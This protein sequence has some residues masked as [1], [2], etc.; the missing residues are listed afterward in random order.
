MEKAS[1]SQLIKRRLLVEELTRARRSDDA[2]RFVEVFRRSTVDPN[3]HQIEAAMFALRRLSAGGAMLGDEVGLGKTIEAGLVITQLRAEGKAHVLVIVPLSLARQWQV[4]LQDLFS[5][6]STLVGQA[7]IGEQISRG[8]QIVGRE[9]ASTAKGRAYLQT[10]GPWDLVIIDEAHEMFSN[11]HVRFSKKDGEYLRSLSKG[12]A[13]RAA[14]VRELIEGS[15]ILLLTAT[16]LQNNL[17]EL[18]GLVQY[19][20]PDHQ[21]LGKFHEF[22]SLFVTGEG[23]RAVVP[24]LAE[25]LRRRLSLVLKRTL[26]H[27]A[28]PF[29]KQPF[30]KRHVHTANFSPESAEADVY[31]AVSRWLAQDT[32]AAYR[33]GHR[34]LMALQLRRR[35][36]SSLEAL[37]TTFKSIRDRMLKMQETGIYPSKSDAEF[38]LEDLSDESEPVPVDRELLDRDLQE[39]GKIEDL[40]RKALSQGVDAKKKKLLE[41][42]QQLESKSIE[43][44]VSD[45]VVIFT[46]SVK[47]LNTLQAFLEE[48]GFANQVTVFAGTND[49]EIAKRAYSSWYEEQGKFLSSPLDINA[50][51][52]GA[53]V[54][55][56]R[57]RTKIF[58]A[59]EAGAK[60][61][62]LQFCNCLIN[63]DLPWNPQRIEQR[64]GRVHRYGQKHDVLIINFV[65][66][67]NEAEQ[68]VYDLLEQ[69]LLVFNDT[70]GASDSIIT[71]P[72][73]SLNFE[74]R[75]NEMLDRCRTE[76][77][78]QLEFDKIHLEFNELQKQ[79]HDERLNAAR[80]LLADLDSSVQARLGSVRSEIGSALSRCDEILLDL[81]RTN[82]TVEIVRVQESRT[83]IRWREK[84][85]HLGPP[86]PSEEYGEPISIQ[87]PDVQLLMSSCLD[88][89]QGKTLF[90]PDF[91]GSCALY[92]VRL[93]GLESEE[94]ILSVGTEGVKFVNHFA[95]DLETG[96]FKL[97]DTAERRQK[98]YVERLLIQ[99]SSRKEDQR[100]FGDKVMADLR[101]KLDAAERARRSASSPVAAAK[102]L[103]LQRRLQT[104]MQKLTASNAEESEKRIKQIEDEERRVRLMQFVKAEPQFLFA[105]NEKVEASNK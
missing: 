20:D 53:L 74:N 37:L 30:R 98:E 51:T 27:Q 36:A 42:I 99:L 85:Y 7:N 6:K 11:I 52:R 58:I 101:K 18:W 29:M 72:E 12:G 38:E 87:H 9:F 21:V 65:N 50:A 15:P 8:I 63:Y 76:E 94:V 25:T 96:V 69:K 45:K 23:G 22:C 10:R 4:E 57:N 47:T 39:L 14:Q 56:F 92:K 103:A 97:K 93:L 84:L 46:E 32:L 61:L 67:S 41:V 86:E 31:R 80:L 83:V 89:T 35:M 70:L 49:G 3:P 2:E 17:Y 28:Q 102:A 5:L 33:R 26:R 24:E 95:D 82:S 75:I 73:F 40:T 13:R 64:I 48:N 43:G 104:E 16:P 88:E 44:V 59:T 34:A 100:L 54:H 1:H 79:L 91:E 105:I 55:E 62:N 77:E 60:G 78:I 90:D 66:L 68:R 19:I 71:P 81:L